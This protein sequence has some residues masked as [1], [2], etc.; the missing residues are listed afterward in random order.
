MWS[1]KQSWCPVRP[2]FCFPL[3][4]RM[5]VDPTGDVAVEFGKIC[6]THPFSSDFTGLI[7]SEWFSIDLRH[8]DTQNI[9]M[10]RRQ[11]ITAPIDPPVILLVSE[12]LF[13]WCMKHEHSVYSRSVQIYKHKSQCKVLK[14][15]ED[16]YVSTL[17]CSGVAFIRYI[18]VKIMRSQIN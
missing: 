13:N 6:S 3:L 17:K 5:S 18:K 10:L 12:S 1:V 14:Q 11:P 2:F 9:V 7:L 4:L 15:N 16:I 8:N